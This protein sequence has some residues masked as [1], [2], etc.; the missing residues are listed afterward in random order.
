VL[1]H[2]AG[3]VELPE[4]GRRGVRRAPRQPAGGRPG[5]GC[6]HVQ[7]R[8]G[9]QR[10][11]RGNSRGH[12]GEQRRRLRDRDL[13]R[14][15]DRPL[16]PARGR[17]LD[18]TPLLAGRSGGS[19][20]RR[21]ASRAERP[22]A[23][24]AYVGGRFGPARTM[25]LDAKGRTLAYGTGT[26]A[27]T[28]LSP[29]P[30]GQR[31]AEIAALRSDARMR[32]TYQVL[33]RET[34]SLRVTRRQA[35][36][37]PGWRFATGLLCE[38][39]E[40]S[41]IVVYANWAGDSAHNAALYRL[42]AGRLRAIWN[43]I[44]FLSC[45]RPGIAYLN[46]GFS[47]DRFVSVDLQ[48]GRVTR[49]ARLPRSPRLVPNTMHTKFTGVAYRLAERSRLFVLDLTTRPPSARS[50]PLVAPEVTGSVYWLPDD[51]VLF[52]PLG[53]P[54][55]ARIL[56]LQLKT[57]SRFQW[58]GGDAALIGSTVFG[59]DR[60]GRL[61]LAKLTTGPQRVLRRLPGRPHLIISARR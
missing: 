34:T 41:S 17:Q 11:D 3:P 40:G 42:S 33:I 49:I 19:A 35:V 38:D 4:T 22:R 48:T 55:T 50:T 44:A 6:S 28:L 9:S 2:P 29:C 15:E 18:G 36:K 27:P 47:A 53:G 8:A 37:L 1:L 39:A 51:R 43:G 56:D 24:G 54:D 7:G 46:A 32:T 60:R 10:E 16:P 59:I 5:A 61:V 58:T 13:R 30:G 25:A 14:P 20:G 23:G 12:D 21:R 57:L 45:L 52:L 31:L 26:G